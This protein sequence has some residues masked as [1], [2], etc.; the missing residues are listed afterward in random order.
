MIVMQWARLVPPLNELIVSSATNQDNKLSADSI[1]AAVGT[2]ILSPK[3]L[4]ASHDV[5]DNESHKKN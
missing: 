3:F 1:V 2:Y 4:L 5:T